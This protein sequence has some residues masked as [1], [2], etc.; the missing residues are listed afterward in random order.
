MKENARQ[1]FWNGARPPL[2]YRIIAAEQRGTK[3]KTKLEIDPVQ[4]D[5]IRLIYR[6]ALNGHD[7]TGPMGLKAIAAHLNTAGLTTRDGGRWS[8]SSVHHALTALTY[9]GEHHFNKRSSKTGEFK[10]EDEHVV[11]KVPPIVSRDQFEAVQ[12]NMERR[13]PTT[14]HSQAYCGPTL[15]GGIIFC[16]QCG[17]AM[18]LRTGRGNGGQYRYY[19]CCTRAR[20]GDKG[21]GGISVR[22]ERVDEAVIHHL[23]HRLLDPKRLATMMDNIVDRRDAFIER[24][25]KHIADL[26][27]CATAA[28]AKL[29][30]LY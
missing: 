18:T 25:S 11:I 26:L 10:D 27:K 30:R 5:K 1:G 23:E 4:A 13:R 21:C 7:N 14:A 8:I 22:M 19:T 12:R 9:V 28:E 6:L 20:T 2:G 29:Q 15:L 17:G 24:R 16:G 3:I